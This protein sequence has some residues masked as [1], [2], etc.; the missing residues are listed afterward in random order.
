MVQQRREQRQD[1]REREQ[2]DEQP[3][4]DDQRHLAGP[5]ANVLR[6]LLCH[7][8]GLAVGVVARGSGASRA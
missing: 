8:C 7:G 1:E 3:H 5:R 6:L 4:E 2:V